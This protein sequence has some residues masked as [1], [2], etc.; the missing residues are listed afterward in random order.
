MANSAFSIRRRI[1]ALA[2]S[3]LLVAAVA[4]AAFINDY[5]ERAADRAFD[6]L[7]A[8]S[9]LTIAGAVQIEDET[10]LVELPFASFAMFSGS[11][12]LFY[13]VRAPD[14]VLVTG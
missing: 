10:V 5:A 7:L 13:T 1:F 8:A 14:G 4:L 9:A 3:L 12:R 6:R 11:D 2:V